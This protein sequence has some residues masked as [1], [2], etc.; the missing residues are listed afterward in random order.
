[1]TEG[2][3]SRDPFRQQMQ[4][5]QTQPVQGRAEGRQSLQGTTT[6]DRS[7]PPQPQQE[8]QERQPR[9]SVWD[10]AERKWR[11]FTH[12]LPPMTE[13]ERL[14][15]RNEVWR[16]EAEIK[17]KGTPRDKLILDLFTWGVILR[18]DPE[19]RSSYKNLVP[20]DYRQFRSLVER[21]SDEELAEELRKHEPPE[22]E[23]P[24][25]ATGTF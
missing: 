5:E 16:L 7:E 10:V 9:P 6:V 15:Y 13:D 19:G 2:E 3:S 14:D 21:S 11:F 1:M 22:Y 4:P 18:S 12:D 25:P 8:D 24:H 17:E 20:E 23:P